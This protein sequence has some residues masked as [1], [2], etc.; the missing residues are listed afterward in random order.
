MEILESLTEER[1]EWIVKTSCRY[2]WANPEVKSSQS[3]L[4]NNLYVNGV[5]AKN[6][7]LMKIESYIDKYFRA[8]NLIN[9]T[10]KIK[11]D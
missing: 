3:I 6:Q 11:Q 1:K 7:V 4:Y 2:V 10:E 9:L 8:F 5:D